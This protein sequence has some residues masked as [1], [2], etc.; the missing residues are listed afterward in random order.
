MCLTLE[1]LEVT[2]LRKGLWGWEHSLGGKVEEEW[3]EK[4]WEG[5]LGG[6]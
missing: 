4:M 2:N 5:R 3:D 1:K 6:G